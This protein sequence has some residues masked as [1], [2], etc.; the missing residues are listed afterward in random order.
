MI[1]RFLLLLLV[2]FIAFSQVP[3]AELVPENGPVKYSTNTGP[4]RIGIIGFVHGHVEGLLWQASQRQDIKIVGIYEPNTALFDRLSAKYKIDSALRYDSI[5]KMLDETKPEAVSVMSS[6]KD[7]LP[8]VEACAPRGIHVMVEKPLAFSNSDAKQIAELANKY[9]VLV[10]TNYETS[11]YA[12]LREAKKMIES[13]EMSPLRK[14][15]FRH[16][17]K[18]PKEIGCS[19]EFLAWLANPEQNGGGAIVDFG[20]YGAILSTWLMDGAKPTSVVASAA[21]LKP[22]VYP[23]VDDDAT[24]VLT[25]G[26]PHNATAIIEASWAWT[27]DNKEA[28]FYTE[29]GSLHAEK[30]DQLS[31]RTENGEP[32][33]IKPAPTGF[34]N[35]WVYLRQVVRGECPVDP[36]S[37]LEMNV[38]AVEILDA[39]RSQCG[40]QK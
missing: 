26:P 14:M 9:G 10:L 4:L 39:A 17:H 24:I 37:S 5:E 21:T 22:D 7:H 11:W 2:S 31:V 13:G 16:G 6:I 12:S 29:K 33:P 38:T 34:E 8:A 3:M 18:G 27:H 20:C 30:W 32:K 35:E 36:L 25:Y 40:K 23:R 15:V 28:D 1:H 19:P